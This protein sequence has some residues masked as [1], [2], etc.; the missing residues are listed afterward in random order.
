MVKIIGNNRVLFAAGIVLLL[1]C[2]VGITPVAAEVGF[3]IFSNPSGA[4]VSVDNFW[5]DITPASVPNVGSGWH[6]IRVSM[7]GYQPYSDSKYCDDKDGGIQTCV[8]NVNLYPNPVSVGWLR[9]NP[10]GAEVWVDGID[11][12]NGAMTIPLSPGNHNLILRK[13]GYYDYTETFTISAGDETARAPG[14]TAY[15]A[16][17]QYGSLQIDSDPAGSAVYLDNNYKGI[18]PAYGAF[19]IT[20]LVPGTYT[21]K[22]VMQDYQTWTQQVQVQAGIV[23]DI[24]AKLIPNPPGPTPDTTGQLYA[25]STPGGAN[26]YIDNVYRGITPLTLRDIPA[27]SHTVMFRLT[28]FQDY[29]TVA[30]VNGGT[31]I[32]VP[33]TLNSARQPVQP[34]KSPVGTATIISAIGICGAVLLIRKRI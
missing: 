31:I 1:T 7:E 33:A 3:R 22:L 19:F 5:F 32:N 34:T 16:Q 14:M 10:F 30:N 23:N 18:E 4:L 17:P 27:G 20:D 29:S 25:Y 24:H 8:V 11:K 6:T 21:L 2:A 15:P 13:P 28:G 26:V 12:G 9:I